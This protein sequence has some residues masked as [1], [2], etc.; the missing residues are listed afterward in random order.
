MITF[1]TFEIDLEIMIIII[2]LPSQP[3]YEIYMIFRATCVSVV[4]IV[5]VRDNIVEGFFIT[6]MVKD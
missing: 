6:L 1:D 3:I 5:R 2:R 4:I